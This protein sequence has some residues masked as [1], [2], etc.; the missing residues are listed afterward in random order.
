MS[1]RLRLILVVLV[2]VIPASV[3]GLLSYGM[4]VDLRQELEQ[5]SPYS[6]TVLDPISIVGR[7]LSFEGRWSEDGAFVA[8][9][10]EELPLSRRPKLRGAIQAVQL[11][12]GSL[13]MFGR[14]IRITDDTEF[15][16]A[17]SLSALAPGQRIE[18]SCKLDA[19]GTWVGR[20]VK[21]H[22]LKQNDKI[23]GPITRAATEGS[24]KRLE[25]EGLP[26]VVPSKLKIDSPRGPVH[27]MELTSRMAFAIQSCLTTANE[28]LKE[29]Y[30][31]RDARTKGDAQR[32][33]ELQSACEDVEDQLEDDCKEFIQVVV[34][35]RSIAEQEMRALSDEGAAELASELKDEIARWLIPLAGNGPRLETDVTRFVALANA[36]VDAAQVFLIDTLEPRLRGEVLPLI[37]AY[38]LEIEEELAEEVQGLAS[39]SATAARVAII[40]TVAGLVLASTLGFFVARSIAKPIGELRAAARKIG[41]GDLSARVQSTAGDEIGM[42]ARTF[43]QMAERLSATTVSIGNLNEVIDSMAGA[44]FL[45]GPDGKI[46]S[47][48]PAASKLLG[49]EPAQLIGTPFTT[50]CPEF[51]APTTSV[52]R[53]GPVASGE[54]RFRTHAGT[55]VPVSFSAS[56]LRG[57]HATVRGYACLA[58]DLTGRKQ[59]E[60]DLRRSLSEKEL[61]LREVHHRV[62]NNLQVISSLLDLQSRTVS[63][64]H[65]LTKFQDSQDRIRSMVLIH[66]QLYRSLNLESIHM[67]AYLELLVAN[68]AQSHVDRPGRINVCVSVDDICL[69]L[70]Q[71]LTCGL[72]VNELVTN[73]FKHAF[74]ADASGEIRVVCQR[75]HEGAI[76]LKVSDNGRGFVGTPARDIGTALGFSLVE[77]LVKQLR[78]SLKIDGSRGAAFRV[79]FSADSLAVAS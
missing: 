22:G 20:K 19:P 2:V 51:G 72:I 52:E 35:T 33:S 46:V 21:T 47:A 12:D 62:K 56:A 27:R 59:L 15:E 29:R 58:Q 48:N 18:I 16:E 55:I 53:V 14:T 50:I 49:Y 3:A 78:G 32:A 64:P 39:H 10:I 37:H 70:D 45:L 25:I 26:I 71:A 31:L 68:L 57:D 1:I 65:A 23:K 28:S 5:L 74:P 69:S 30:R 43:N 73:A 9:N 41:D 34:R 24:E 17:G 77:A 75:T 44:L 61:L 54:H 40:A 7:E 8:S 4:H 6:K 36:D 63:D 79:E 67:Q 11:A 76:E 42:L 60:E 13:T 38:Q 66:E